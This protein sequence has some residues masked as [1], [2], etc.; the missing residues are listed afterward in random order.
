MV[1]D[2]QAFTGGDT[3]RWSMVH[4]IAGRLALGDQDLIDRAVVYAHECGWIEIQGFH[5]VK[6]T[7]KGQHLFVK[8]PKAPIAP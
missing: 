6:L 2:L 8:T 3:G 5:S 1:L 7:D 4:S